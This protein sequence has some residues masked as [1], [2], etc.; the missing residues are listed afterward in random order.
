M[1]PANHR[2]YELIDTLNQPN[3]D[4][5]I[6]ALAFDEAE[7]PTDPTLLT[8]AAALT[9]QA[10]ASALNQINRNPDNPDTHQARQ[11][12]LPHLR[13][14]PPT[15]DELTNTI[16]AIK[17]ALA[18]T[19]PAADLHLSHPEIMQ[20]KTL[21]TPP[22]TLLISHGILPHDETKGVVLH[23]F[24]HKPPDQASDDGKGFTKRPIYLTAHSTGCHLQNRYGTIT[25]PTLFTTYMK[26]TDHTV[27]QALTPRGLTHS[28][29]TNTALEHAIRA[30]EDRYLSVTVHPIPGA[31]S[32][33]TREA[34]QRV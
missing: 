11:Q 12:V 16:Q 4:P 25:A 27:L 32:S 15:P 18:L 23:F 7:D 9:Q 20:L 8:I 2:C 5:S 6:L 14:Q 33:P 13:S 24:A 10:A 19:L 1:N 21:L 30:A 26:H 34:G 3:Q 17:N 29:F 28:E 31:L 22:N